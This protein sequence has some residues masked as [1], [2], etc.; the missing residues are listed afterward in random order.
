MVLYFIVSRN[1]DIIIQPL[2]DMLTCVSCEYSA[3]C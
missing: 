2:D 3:Q 1:S